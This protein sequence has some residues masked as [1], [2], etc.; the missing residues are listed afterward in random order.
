MVNLLRRQTQHVTALAEARSL[1]GERLAEIVEMRKNYQKRVRSLIEAAQ[2]S[3]HLRTDVAAKY[4]GLMLE[5]LL[6]R[7]VVWYRKND[8]LSPAELSETF[9]KLFISGAAR[10]G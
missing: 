2:K 10:R 5:G 8:A 9:C 3:G 6:D 7:T 4:L 1:S